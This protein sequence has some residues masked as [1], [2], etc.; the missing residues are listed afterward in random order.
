MYTDFDSPYEPPENPEV[1]IDT[2]RVSPEAGADLV[3]GRLGEWGV[4]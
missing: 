1:H 3:I 2:T 4:L